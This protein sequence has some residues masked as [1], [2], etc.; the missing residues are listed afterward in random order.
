[1]ALAGGLAACGS[2]TSPLTTSVL[3]ES[4]C[5]NPEGARTESIGVAI[6]N[7]S[8]RP[9]R[10]TNVSVKFTSNLRFLGS[11]TV[12]QND[13]IG[14]VYGFPPAAIAPS[15]YS[16]VVAGGS[17][18]HPSFVGVILGFA[19]AETAG[20]MARGIVIRYWQGTTNYTLQLAYKIFVGNA[21][22]LTRTCGA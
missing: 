3:G 17:R 5:G 1:L 15:L 6:M 18:L 4:I 21:V 9:I 2:G 19:P 12:P 7:Q 16:P 11:R 13:Q 8:T 14:A 20:G 10:I 22:Y